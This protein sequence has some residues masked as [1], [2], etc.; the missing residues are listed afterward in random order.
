MF[1]IFSL[2]CNWPFITKGF[3]GGLRSALFKLFFIGNKAI[4]S[5]ISEKGAQIKPNEFLFKDK[6]HVAPF[7]PPSTK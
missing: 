4:L 3:E 2:N 6:L 5:L 7:F 1:N